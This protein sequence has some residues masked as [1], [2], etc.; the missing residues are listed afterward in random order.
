M[1]AEQHTWS[2]HLLR[3]ATLLALEL[4]RV[5]SIDIRGGKSRHMELRE[6]LSHHEGRLH[7][8]NNLNVVEF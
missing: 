7:N 6:I 5:G 8:K 3:T 1:A 2:F 4:A